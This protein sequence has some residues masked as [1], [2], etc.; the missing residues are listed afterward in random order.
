[1]TW[2]SSPGDYSLTSSAFTSRHEVINIIAQYCA[3]LHEQFC[4][5]S[6]IVLEANATHRL[7]SRRVRVCIF[8]PNSFWLLLHMRKW[9]LDTEKHSPSI[10]KE[11]S[12]PCGTMFPWGG[13]ALE[14]CAGVTELWS[15]MDTVK[16]KSELSPSDNPVSKTEGILHGNTSDWWYSDNCLSYE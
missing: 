14:S 6:K 8:D 13:F 1:M 11:N 2:H 10:S 15:G 5:G 4:C 3:L 7:Q 12:G 16:D 9:G